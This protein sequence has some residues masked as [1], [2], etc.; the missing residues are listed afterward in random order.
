MAF[1]RLLVV[2]QVMEYLQQ[3]DGHNS[4][5]RDQGNV[6]A[7]SETQ[8]PFSFREMRSSSPFRLVRL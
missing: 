1:L 8:K 5:V 2:V 7:K 4:I 6:E 3:I